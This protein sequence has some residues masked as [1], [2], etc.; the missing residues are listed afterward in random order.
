MSDKIPKHSRF[1]P[2]K[3]VIC[4]AEHSCA[5]LYIDKNHLKPQKQY[6][7]T[8]TYTNQPKK[9]VQPTLIPTETTKTR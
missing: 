1:T 8:Q 4:M 2:S 6:H 3:T 5:L 7:C 9:P